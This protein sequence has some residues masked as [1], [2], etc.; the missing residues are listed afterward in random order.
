MTLEFVKLVL[1]LVFTLN[2][3]CQGLK[4]F[5]NGGF[6]YQEDGTVVEETGNDTADNSAL[7]YQIFG[8]K[9][10]QEN[11]NK[12][13]EFFDIFGDDFLPSFNNEK[14]SY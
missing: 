4:S 2:V 11:M 7:R 8:I 14:V 12:F 5:T 10:A 6:I 9:E 1:S 13:F 3:T